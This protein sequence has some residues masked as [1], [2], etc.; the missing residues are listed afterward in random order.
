MAHQVG[1]V[2]KLIL[3]QTKAN[4]YL[5]G[6]TDDKQHFRVCKF[7][8][9]KVSNSELLKHGFVSTKKVVYGSAAF[10]AFDNAYLRM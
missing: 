1:L 4:C 9:L 3:Y 5:V 2:R 8:R 7:A 10:F 6:R